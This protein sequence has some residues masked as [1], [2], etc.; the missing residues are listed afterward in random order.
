MIV[1]RL[2]LMCQ[3]IQHSEF[4]VILTFSFRTPYFNVAVTT[5]CDAECVLY[6]CVYRATWWTGCQ[7]W[8]LP[9]HQWVASTQQRYTRLP[10]PPSTKVPSLLLINLSGAPVIQTIIANGCYKRSMRLRYNVTRRGWGQ[11]ESGFEKDRLTKNNTDLTG[12][13]C[14]IIAAG[15]AGC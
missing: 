8:S 4:A 11:H 10:Y 14:C 5:V 1:Q 15:G 13:R 2:N 9:G 3:S 12:E 7:Q 6:T